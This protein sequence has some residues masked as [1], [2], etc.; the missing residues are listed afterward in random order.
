MDIITSTLTAGAQSRGIASPCEKR[1][2]RMQKLSLINSLVVKISGAIAT[3]ILHR[4]M[5]IGSVEVGRAFVLW[6]VLA[7]ERTRRSSSSA[8]TEI[9]SFRAG[10]ASDEIHGAQ[11]PAARSRYRIACTGDM[12]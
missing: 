12:R 8:A 1:R 7:H 3:G 10:H 9:R 4:V 5:V 6:A 11:W 2:R